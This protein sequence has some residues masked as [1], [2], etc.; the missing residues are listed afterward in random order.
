MGDAKKLARVNKIRECPTWT[1]HKHRVYKSLNITFLH[2]NSGR[3]T[4][5]GR[6]LITG[7]FPLAPKNSEEVRLAVLSR[8]PNET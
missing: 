6:Y 4:V 7:L 3:L 1:K 5:M 2:L 8:P